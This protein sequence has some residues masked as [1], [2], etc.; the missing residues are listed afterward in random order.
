M[1]NSSYLQIIWVINVFS[2]PLW[3]LS[4]PPN[5][6][7]NH[8][9]NKRWTV[10]MFLMQ[11]GLFAVCLEWFCEECTLVI[12]HGKRQRMTLL[13]RREWQDQVNREKK[14]VTVM[15]VWCARAAPK[16]CGCDTYMDFWC[17][18]NF[19]NLQPL[20]SIITAIT[21]ITFLFVKSQHAFSPNCPWIKHEESLNHKDRK[22]D[23]EKCLARFFME[24]CRQFLTNQN[25]MSTL[26]DNVVWENMSGLSVIN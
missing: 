18:G 12:L 1:Q 6:A 19:C 25:I 14:W 15:C 10:G 8:L 26:R 20:F 21:I 7:Q 16:E 9:L 11:I 5:I 4:L 23:A 3:C 13:G 24:Y 17:W 2:V 22:C